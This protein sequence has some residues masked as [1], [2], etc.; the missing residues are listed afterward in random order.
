MEKARAKRAY[1]SIQQQIGAR[2][3]NNDSLFEDLLSER[4]FEL[5]KVSL[6][7]FNFMISFIYSSVKLNNHINQIYYLLLMQ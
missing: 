3:I 7:I 5:E 2:D 6:F 1:D 4:A